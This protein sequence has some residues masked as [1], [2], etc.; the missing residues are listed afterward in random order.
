MLL[1]DRL[2]RSRRCVEV[3]NLSETGMRCLIVV[4]YVREKDLLRDN[5]VVVSMN[6]LKIDDSDELGLGSLHTLW[7]GRSSLQC[8]GAEYKGGFPIMP[9][10]ALV[11][12]RGDSYSGIMELNL[13]RGPHYM[14]HCSSPVSKTVP[15][16]LRERYGFHVQLV[17]CSESEEGGQESMV[18]PDRMALEQDQGAHNMCLVDSGTGRKLQEALRI[19]S[20]HTEEIVGDFVLLGRCGRR[21]VDS[22]A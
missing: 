12:D 1:R 22:C 10:S 17:G 15:P 5:E 3:T 11:M 9:A 4:G 2:N 19:E 13:A 20:S 6:T 18:Y 16:H 8:A 7:L 14:W 21:H